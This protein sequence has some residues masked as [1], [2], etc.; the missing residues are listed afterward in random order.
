MWHFRLKRSFSSHFSNPVFPPSAFYFVSSTASCWKTTL[1]AGFLLPTHEDHPAGVSMRKCFLWRR[2]SVVGYEK[3]LSWAHFGNQLNLLRWPLPVTMTPYNQCAGTKNETWRHLLCD[4]SDFC[5]MWTPCSRT[6]ELQ[7]GCRH[8]LSS[9]LFP[10]LL[11][12][13]LLVCHYPHPSTSSLFRPFSEMLLCATAR[14]PPGPPRKWTVHS[15]A[16]M[17]LRLICQW[18]VAF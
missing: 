11:F 4:S 15:G 5:L 12:S 14:S 10:F 18:S 13:S 8:A 16:T 6:P 9:F 7:V 3:Q 17:Q 2:V 1:D